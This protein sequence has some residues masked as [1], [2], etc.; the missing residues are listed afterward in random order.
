MSYK[1]S[2]DTS[3]NRTLVT[4]IVFVAV[5][6]SAIFIFDKYYSKEF[7]VFKNMSK[8]EAALFI[9]FDNMQKVFAGEV[10]DEMTI[11]DALNAAVVAGQI[12]LTYHVD[13]DN[14]TKITEI[15]SHIADGKIQFAFYINSRKL[16][17]S[18]LNKTHIKPGD[19]ITIRLE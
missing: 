17:Q 2:R 10:V 11:L 18:E 6:V 14:N 4:Q 8:S 3:I 12:K 13:S 1:E 19:K 15:N 9:D 7:S 16:D 5:I